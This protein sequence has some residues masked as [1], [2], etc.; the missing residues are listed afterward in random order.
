M[1]KTSQYGDCYGCG[2]YTI[3]CRCN[4]PKSYSSDEIVCPYCEAVDNDPYY[5]MEGEQADSDIKMECG[6]CGREYTLIFNY[7]VTFSTYAKP[8]ARP[9]GGEC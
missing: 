5:A 4:T 3:D 1:S 6:S 7:S 9:A 2:S 8:A